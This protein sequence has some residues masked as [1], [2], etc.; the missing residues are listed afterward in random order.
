MS[1]IFNPAVME[2]SGGVVETE[3]KWLAQHHSAATNY[4]SNGRSWVR[5]RHPGTS[6]LVDAVFSA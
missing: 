5:A 6:R 4:T 2:N 3:K 1:P